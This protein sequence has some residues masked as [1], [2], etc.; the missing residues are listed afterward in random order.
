MPDFTHLTDKG[1]ITMVNVSD[2]SQTLREAKFYGRIRMNPSTVCLIKQNKIQKGNVLSTAKLAGIMAA[3]NTG[4]LIPLCHPLKVDYIDLLFDF[5]SDYISVV[6]KV[7]AFDKTGVEMEASVA[8]AVALLTIYDMCKAVDRSMQID[9]IKLI[10]KTGGKSIY[11]RSILKGIN[12]SKKK[13]RVKFPVKQAELIKNYGIKGDAHAQKNSKRQVSLLSTLSINK[14][15]KRL[16]VT[17]GAFG[18]NLIIQDIPLWEL[19]VGTKITFQQ[20]A[21]LLVTMIGKKC[22]APCQIYKKM[23]D[24]I[25]PKQGIFAKVIKKG[26]ISVN[27]E[28]RFEYND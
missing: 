27:E 21:E 24:C 14:V 28:I 6:S 26:I 19:P 13:G 1:Q 22:H 11:Y 17:D 9:D 20:G 10:M 18:E 7:H 4:H 23:G 25:M 8:V 5:H 16:N 2:K 15:K 3:K 12:I